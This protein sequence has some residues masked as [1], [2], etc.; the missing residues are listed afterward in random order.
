MPRHP[1]VALWR[2][3]WILRP[4]PKRLVSRNPIVSLC[5]WILRAKIDG[6]V[7]RK[8]QIWQ[9][10]LRGFELPTC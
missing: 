5:G 7:K 1:T 10:L 9:A 6:K 3:R 4:P 8:C 2:R